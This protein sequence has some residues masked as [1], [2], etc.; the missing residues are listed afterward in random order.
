M[1]FAFIDVEKTSYPMRILCRVLESIAKRV[2]RLAKLES[3]R[4]RDLDDEQASTQGRRSLQNRSWNVR[5]PSRLASSS[6]R[7]ESR[8]WKEARRST[9]GR[10]G[11]PGHLSAQVPGDDEL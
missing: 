7:R 1:R 8:G 11:V 2:L 3:H 5:Q 6:S 9:H 4:K 10:A